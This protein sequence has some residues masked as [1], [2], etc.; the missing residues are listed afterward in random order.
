MIQL[1]PEKGPRAALTR[2]SFRENL[3]T[4]LNCDNDR[5]K[6]I[7]LIGAGYVAGHAA[8]LLLD[9]GHEL[10]IGKRHPDQGLPPELAGRA[11]VFRMDVNNP[12]SFP[13]ALPQSETLIYCVSSDAFSEAHYRRAYFDG[14]CSVLKALSGSDSRATKRIIFISSTGVFAQSDESQVDENSPAE[15]QGFSGRIMLE[16]EQALQAFGRD[17]PEIQTVAL[18][19]SGIYGPGRTRM[20][21]T[22]ARA[23]PVTEKRWTQWTNRIHRDD[24]AA[25]IAHLVNRPTVK[26][27]YVASDTSPARY[28]EIAAWV[29]QRLGRPLAVPRTVA[30]MAGAAKIGAPL[31]NTGGLERGGDKRCWST[32]LLAEG[33]T[34]KYASFKDGYEPLIASDK[35]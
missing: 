17:H 2:S 29:A 5:M 24:C 35:V 12:L 8:A 34:F 20:I 11:A 25:A 7:F 10:A 27:C 15:P 6:S 4:T 14:L 19:F 30:P 13:A 9:Q 31:P 28:G 26:P 3:A 33:F 21:Q 23:E 16:A 32:A 22:I 18:R 1:R